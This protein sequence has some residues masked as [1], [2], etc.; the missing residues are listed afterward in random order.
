MLFGTQEQ[1][2]ETHE[3]T[4]EGDR[5]IEKLLIL[6]AESIATESYG[7]DTRSVV[8]RRAERRH[9]QQR[10]DVLALLTIYWG[11]ASAS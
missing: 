6:P 1:Q 8:P 2:C 3:P 11:C 7:R 9:P 4:K 10:E 5:V